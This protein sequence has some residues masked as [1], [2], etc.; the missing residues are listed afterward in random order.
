MDP[1]KFNDTADYQYINVLGVEGVYTAANI[2]A[3]TLPDGFR[4][5]SLLPGEES[6]FGE[7]RAGDSPAAMGSL[8]TKE[9]LGLDNSGTCALN[10]S[11]WSFS[12]KD[13]QFEPYF[14]QMLSIDAQIEQAEAKRDAKRE[15]T[16]SKKRGKDAPE[17]IH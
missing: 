12:D 14:G 1:I 7:V 2:K 17:Q 8:I 13:F 3:D 11:D 5:Y 10:D 6:M 15:E 16:Q 4:K 9:R